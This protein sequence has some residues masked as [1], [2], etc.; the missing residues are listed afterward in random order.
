MLQ[1]EKLYQTGET[2]MPIRGIRNPI[3]TKGDTPTGIFST[4]GSQRQDG[5]SGPHNGLK[6]AALSVDGKLGKSGSGN[7]LN[8]GGQGERH[9][10][11]K[12]GY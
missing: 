3:P 7:N 8:T 12:K 4:R 6:N 1:L 11:P 5:L 10:A 2:P 9:Q